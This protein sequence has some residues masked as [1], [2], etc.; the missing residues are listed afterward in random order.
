MAAPGPTL[1]TSHTVE[2]ISAV[3]SDLQ[4]ARA[5]ISANPEA[6]QAIV[7]AKLA[8]L[9]GELADLARVLPSCAG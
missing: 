6:D 4:L 7:A 8:A 5:A 1:D 2:T 9:A 3:I